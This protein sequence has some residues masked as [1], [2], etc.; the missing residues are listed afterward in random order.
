MRLLLP[1]LGVFALPS[2]LLLDALRLRFSQGGPGARSVA[3]Q[4]RAS[5]GFPLIG[6]GRGFLFQ[7]E[8]DH[9]VM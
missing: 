4:W 9:V 3:A 8:C 5:G 2:L 1:L 6:G 7:S